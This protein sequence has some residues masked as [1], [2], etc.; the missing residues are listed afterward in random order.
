MSET[1]QTIL[2]VGVAAFLMLHPFSGLIWSVR[3]D[4]G[5]ENY[6]FPSMCG[7]GLPFLLGATYIL[8]A[9]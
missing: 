8:L 6:K 1:A 4:P 5:R 9:F 3:S 7:P 2:A